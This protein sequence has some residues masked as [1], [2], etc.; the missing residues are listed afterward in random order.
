V[1]KTFTIE[2]HCGDWVLYSGRVTDGDWGEMRHGWNLC[3]LSRFDHN[4][5][6]TRKLIE[7]ALNFYMEHKKK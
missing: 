6:N 2:E 1:D 3:T 4:G 5:E 7:D